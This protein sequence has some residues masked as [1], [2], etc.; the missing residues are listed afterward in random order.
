MT[1]T[2]EELQ[3]DVQEAIKW[4]PLLHAAEIGVTV[5]DGV[6]TLTGSVD[7]YSKKTEAETAAKNVKGVK[8][9]VEKIEIK[10][11]DLTKR[12]D[13]EI[14]TS[15]LNAL[16]WTS[17]P[18]KI[19]VK[20]ENGWVTLEGELVWNYQKESAR[21][22][23]KSLMGVKGI[24]N[25][26]TV[27][28]NPQ[29]TIEKTDIELAL[30]R[31]WAIDDKNIHVEVLANNVTLTGTVHSLYQ[32]EEAGRIAWNAPGVWTVK[33]DLEIGFKTFY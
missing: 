25:N 15:V 27:K 23:V 24:F 30:I 9:V 31:N 17:A 6:V 20:V 10:F 2:N 29:D 12:D 22:S 5:K 7:N 16:K 13:G 21:T 14:A 3:K 28:A 19:K 11:S 8:A 33:N 32:K 1:R 26:I 4:E 18:D